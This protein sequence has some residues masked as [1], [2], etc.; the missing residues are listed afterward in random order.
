MAKEKSR[1]KEPIRELIQTKNAPGA[2]GTYSQA[3]S[4]G[5]F[6]YT[7]GQI[8]INPASGKIESSDTKS[9]SLQALHNI[10]AIL[11][12]KN[13]SLV[14]IVKLTVYLKDLNDFSD[15]NEAFK[16]FFGATNFP[17]R[18]TVEVAGLPLGARVEIDCVAI[19]S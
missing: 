15:L 12:A 2:V 18:S 17:A 4:A 16:E 5:G 10:A 6:L 7:S 1:I 9:Q 14:N 13:L 11:N 3:V 19:E 8:G